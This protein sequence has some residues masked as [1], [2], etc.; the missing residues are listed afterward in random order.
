PPPP[1]RPLVNPR[2]DYS[3]SQ[4]VGKLMNAMAVEAGGAAAAYLNAA[5]MMAAGIQAFACAA[6][7]F[8]VNWRATIASLAIALVIAT[9]LH[10]LVRMAKRAAKRQTKT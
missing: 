2:W 10:R 4:P 8:T 9:G 1:P 3:L 5:T 6:V 7:A